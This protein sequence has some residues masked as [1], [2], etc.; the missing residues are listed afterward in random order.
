MKND[1]AALI[2][3]FAILSLVSVAS[4]ALAGKK[5]AEKIDTLLKD[6][7]AELKILRKKIAQQ[8][9]AISKVGK[10]ESAV[11]KNLQKIAQSYNYEL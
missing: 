4:P 7:Q 1:F 6:E 5:V 2:T 8:E 10:K 9:N 11:L 3:F